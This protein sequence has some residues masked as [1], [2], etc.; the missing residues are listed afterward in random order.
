MCQRCAVL[1]LYERFVIN[2]DWK[3][4]R[5][6][7]SSTTLTSTST[8][9][10]G[11][12]YSTTF[13]RLTNFY[14]LPSQKPTFTCLARQC[15][16]T[17]RIHFTSHSSRRAWRWRYCIFAWVTSERGQSRRSRRWGERRR[18]RVGER[19]ERRYGGRGVLDLRAIKVCLW[20]LMNKRRTYRASDDLRRIYP[21]PLLRPCSK[22]VRVLRVQRWKLAN[23]FIFVSLTETMALWRWV[24]VFPSRCALLKD[25]LHMLSNVAQLIT[26]CTQ[27]IVPPHC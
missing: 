24:C 25:P 4:A 23:G 1:V 9:Y 10:N 17:S 6:Q 16:P 18:K 15:F 19:E 3:S 12:C 5:G 11:S 8:F 21:I 26:F 27:L 22:N 2:S 7:V 20:T 13:T 14:L